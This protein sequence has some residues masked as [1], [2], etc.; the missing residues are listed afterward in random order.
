[1]Y[2]QGGSGVPAQSQPRRLLPAH[3]LA[4]SFPEF[5]RAGHFCRRHS[6]GHPGR[7]G[8]LVDSR[9]E[10]TAWLCPWVLPGE[11]LRKDTSSLHTPG[12]YEVGTAPTTAHAGLL[13]PEPSLATLGMGWVLA[14]LDGFLPEGIKGQFFLCWSPFL[15]PLY[16]GAQFRSQ[17]REVWENKAFH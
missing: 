4:I 13:G 11:A 12:P 15:L 14:P 6:G 17:S 16:P 2:C 8:W 3:A 5:R 10:R 1:M 7:R 9:E